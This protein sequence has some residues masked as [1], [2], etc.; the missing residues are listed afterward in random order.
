LSVVAC[1]RSSGVPEVWSSVVCTL[2]SSGPVRRYPQKGGFLL[3]DFGETPPLRPMACSHS[4]SRPSPQRSRRPLPHPLKDP[5]M[6]RSLRLHTI[7]S[8]SRNSADRQ[9]RLQQRQK[10]T[11]FEAGAPTSRRHSGAGRRARLQEA[12]DRDHS[13]PHPPERA[14]SPATGAWALAWR[15]QLLQAQKEE[16]PGASLWRHRGAP[17]PGRCR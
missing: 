13:P 1:C 12:P 8:I 5:L 14:R 9:R 6:A 16:R 15:Q 11:S 10:G 7:A 4:G 3:P 2:F 17:R